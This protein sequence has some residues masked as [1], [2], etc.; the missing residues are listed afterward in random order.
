MN[1]EVDNR[2]ESHQAYLQTQ[3]SFW[4]PGSDDYLAGE[5]VFQWNHREHVRRMMGEQQ[6]DLDKVDS[7]LA[8]LLF[9]MKQQLSKLG[10]NGGGVHG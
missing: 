9:E 2:H 1:P 5:I 8:G 6:K 7:V 4:S 3:C 10:R